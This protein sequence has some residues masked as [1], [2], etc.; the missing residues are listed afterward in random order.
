MNDMAE[1][2]L[3]K[4]LISYL[5]YERDE[6]NNIYLRPMSALSPAALDK[7]IAAISAYTTNKIID[8]LEYLAEQALEYG[9][10]DAER[11]AWQHKG[12]ADRMMIP[13]KYVTEA[14]NHRK[15]G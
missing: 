3:K 11:Y 6:V 7:T 8:I 2:E 1:D 9:I 15:E 4:I 12:E 10:T 13:L 14:L 5:G